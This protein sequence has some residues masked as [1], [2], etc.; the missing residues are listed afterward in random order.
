MLRLSQRSRSPP[1]LNAHA[2]MY[3]NCAEHSLAD[4]NYCVTVH[5]ALPSCNVTLS[6]ECSALKIFSCL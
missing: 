4:C 2:G 6:L 5:T 3:L 1:R